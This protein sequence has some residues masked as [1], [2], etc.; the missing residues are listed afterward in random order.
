VRIDVKN[1]RAPG[2]DPV[3]V[4]AAMGSVYVKDPPKSG[5]SD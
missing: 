4:A 5:A 2:A 1:T 3:L